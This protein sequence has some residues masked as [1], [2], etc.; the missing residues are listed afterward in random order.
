[1]KKVSI[2]LVL[3]LLVTGSALGVTSLP[4][5]AQVYGPPPPAAALPPQP[6]VGPNTPWVYYNG[7]W[8]LNGVLY[9][10]FGPK[11]GWAPY[12]AYAPVYIVRPAKWYG[13]HWHN[14]YRAHPVYWQNFQRAYPYWRTHH[15]GYRY[16]ERF[17]NRYHHGQGGGWQ[18]GYHGEH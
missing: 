8:F 7:D 17:Y 4:A 5:Q 15:V 10:F 1:M 11:Y 18:H 14:W 6:W 13:P 9:Y 3:A 2:L 16:D 12:Y